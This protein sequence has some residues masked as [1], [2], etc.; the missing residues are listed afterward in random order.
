MKKIFIPATLAGKWALGLGFAFVIAT[1]LSLFFAIAVGGDSA[2]IDASPLLTIL[3]TLLSLLFTL[4]GPLSLIFG[5]YTLIRYREWLVGQLLA[6]FY[7]V[8]LVL[9]LFGEFLFPH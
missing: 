7:A 9:F 4:S 3:A 8:T 2:L 6:A 5:V 1:A